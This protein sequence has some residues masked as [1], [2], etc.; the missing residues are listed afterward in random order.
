MLVNA[1]KILVNADKILVN[2][3]EILVN[4][5]ERTRQWCRPVWQTDH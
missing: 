1:D 5:G 3:G 2:A 4:A